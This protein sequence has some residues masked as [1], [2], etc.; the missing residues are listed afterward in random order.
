MCCVSSCGAGKR[1]VT[2]PTAHNRKQHIG[3]EAADALHDGDFVD[4][5][6]QFAWCA[7]T[8]VGEH[9]LRR[10]QGSPRRSVGRKIRWRRRCQRRVLE[11]IEVWASR[12]ANARAS[13][14][15]SA[16]YQ[17]LRVSRATTK[18]TMPVTTTMSTTVWPRTRARAVSDVE[19]IPFAPA[20]VSVPTAR[21]IA[22]ICESV[23]LT[24]PAPRVTVKL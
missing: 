10:V 7:G 14:A 16:L 19:V 15:L 22:S 2:V 18:A 11:A 24:P 20:V 8:A 21:W 5:L 23:G 3:G 4:G 9:W 12:V 1:A 6:V 17:S 13:Q